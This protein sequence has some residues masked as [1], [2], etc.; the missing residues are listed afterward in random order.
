V[1]RFC[2]NEEPPGTI[3]YVPAYLKYAIMEDGCSDCTNAW[4]GTMTYWFKMWLYSNGRSDPA[5]VQQCERTWS[6]SMTTV[7]VNPPPG[8]T[9]DPTP[10]FD[11]QTNVCSSTP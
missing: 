6:R 3:I 10:L 5:A 2:G 7:E 9:V 11:P 1:S 8:R 4:N